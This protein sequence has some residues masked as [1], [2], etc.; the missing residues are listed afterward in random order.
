M[1]VLHSLIMFMAGRPSEET[2]NLKLST[3]SISL[4]LQCYHST[5]NAI[6]FISSG[7]SHVVMEV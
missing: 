3:D 2:V 5:T 1:R 7:Y 6:Q 4:K